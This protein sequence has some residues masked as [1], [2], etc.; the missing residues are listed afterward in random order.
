MLNLTLTSP[1]S[2]LEIHSIIFIILVLYCTNLIC[3]FP[4]SS[5]SSINNLYYLSS[6]SSLFTT[7]FLGVFPLLSQLPLLCNSCTE[8]SIFFFCLFYLIHFILPSWPLGRPNCLFPKCHLSISMYFPALLM[9]LTFQNV[10]PIS[11]SG[12]QKK[13]N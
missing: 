9:T 3:P 6:L 12:S 5:V 4:G 13:R 1:H 11:L 8:Q 10:Y 7:R 2:S